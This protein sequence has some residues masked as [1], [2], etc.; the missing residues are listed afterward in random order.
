MG[1]E[2]GQAIKNRGKNTLYNTGW[3]SDGGRGA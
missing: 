1:G 2:W 3:E